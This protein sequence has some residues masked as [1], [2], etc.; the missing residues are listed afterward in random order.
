MSQ[1]VLYTTDIHYKILE[2]HDMTFLSFLAITF[3][4]FSIIHTKCSTVQGCMHLSM[5]KYILINKYGRFFFPHKGFEDFGNSRKGWGGGGFG[6]KLSSK[7]GVVSKG[8]PVI[9]AFPGK[10]I[11][12]YL[13]IPGMGVLFL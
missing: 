7:P 1:Q 6:V 2:S 5:I 11:L 10:G 4:V 3:C 9:L 13:E 8:N 12:C